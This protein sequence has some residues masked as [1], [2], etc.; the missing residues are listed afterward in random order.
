VVV[1]TLDPAARRATV[2]VAAS[3]LRHVAAE[4]VYLGIHPPASGERERAEF[5]RDLLDARSAALA[6]H[7]L[8]MRT[9]LRFGN[10]A[11][12]LVKELSANENSMLVLGTSDPD[13]IDWSWLGRLLEGQPERP[14]LIVNAGRGDHAGEA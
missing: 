9:E 2:P 6:E 12:E 7:G 8:D 1:H 11:E 10:V 5:T 14:V 13:S 4:A 3:L